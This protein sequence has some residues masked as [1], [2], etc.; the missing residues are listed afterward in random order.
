MGKKRYKVVNRKKQLHSY[1]HLKTSHINRQTYVFVV[2]DS[3]KKQ[4]QIVY[5]SYIEVKPAF[6]ANASGLAKINV[7]LSRGIK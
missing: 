3:P 5:N 6:S 7:M 1:N 4:L 2:D